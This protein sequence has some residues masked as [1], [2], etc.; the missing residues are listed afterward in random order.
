MI[1]VLCAVHAES[2][3]SAGRDRVAGEA[4]RRGLVAGPFLL[5]AGSATSGRALRQSQSSPIYS[6]EMT[7][8]RK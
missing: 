1:C 5:P 6:V 4:G 2:T 8:L 3:S 7:K